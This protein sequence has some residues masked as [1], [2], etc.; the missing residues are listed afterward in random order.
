M[1]NDE[2]SIGTYYCTLQPLEAS[3]TTVHKQVNKFVVY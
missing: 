2:G 3:I 1:A